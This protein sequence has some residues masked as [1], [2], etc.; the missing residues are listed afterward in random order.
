MV[1]H[2]LSDWVEEVDRLVVLDP[3]GTDITA[4]AAKLSEES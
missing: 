3:A 2:Q 1:E 4:K